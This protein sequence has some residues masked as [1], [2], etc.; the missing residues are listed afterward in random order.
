MNRTTLDK[1]FRLEGGKTSHLEPEQIRQGLDNSIENYNLNGSHQTYRQ[2][3]TT[4][5]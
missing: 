5:S 4:P 3:T 2:K 1:R